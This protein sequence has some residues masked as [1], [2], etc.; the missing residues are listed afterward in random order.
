MNLSPQKYI[1][2]ITISQW[3]YHLKNIHSFLLFKFNLIGLISSQN[4]LKF[5]CFLQKSMNNCTNFFL[6]YPIKVCF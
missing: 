4:G 6:N 5:D 2:Y 1:K 3:I